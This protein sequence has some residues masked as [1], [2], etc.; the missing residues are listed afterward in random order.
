VNASDEMRR[1][2]EHK[3]LLYRYNFLKALPNIT[4]RIAG[5][6]GTAAT[7]D[8]AVNEKM[9]TDEKQ[10]ALRNYRSLASGIV[11]INVPD[12]LAWSSK[13]EWENVFSPVDLPAHQLRAYID[14]FPR[15][16]LSSSLKA[17]LYT[18]KDEQFIKEERERIE[19]QDV[20]I[21]HPD[22]LSLAVMGLEETPT[23]VLASRIAASLYLLD[24]D[25]LS[26]SDVATSGLDLAK[27]LEV[28]F[29]IDLQMVKA[30]LESCLS[31]A[32]THLHPP[33][34][35]ARALRLSNSV[36]SNE[37]ND[38]EALLCRAYIAQ[39]AG[40][41]AQARD[42]FSNVKDA[43]KQADA[44]S[45]RAKKLRKL[46]ISAN[47]EREA[48]LE[49]AWCDVKL[50]RLEEG[51]E[52]LQEVI[53][54]TDDSV[55]VNR[56]EQAKVWWRLGSC[57]WMMGGSHRDETS[58]A[59]TCFITALKHDSSYAPAFTSLGFYY[60]RASQPVDPSRAVKCFQKAFELDSREDE[61]ARQLAQV[62]ADEDDWD[63][64]YLV[65]RRT[66]DGEGGSL[67]LSGEV[68]S[69]RRHITR[70]SWAW[71]AIGSTE[72]IRQD[73]EK[74]IV[75]FQVAL[76]S[77][78]EDGSIWMRLG[79]AYTASG[80]LEAGIKTFEK[81][82]EIFRGT[83]EEWQPMY[84]IAIVQKQQGKLMEA[85]TRLEELCVVQPEKHEIR[86][87]C[88]EVRLSLSIH[89]IGRGY[90]MRG[91]DGIIASIQEARETAEIQEQLLASWKVVADGLFHYAALHLDENDEEFLHGLAQGIIQ[92]TDHYKVD[93]GLPSIF[94]ATAEVVSSKTSSKKKA[95]LMNVYLNKLRITLHHDDEQVASSVWMDLAQGLHELCSEHAAEQD[96]DSAK[97]CKNQAI[98]CTKEALKREPGNGSYWNSLG[99]LV[100]DSSIKLSQHCYIKAIETDAKDA[101]P[102]TSL[103]FLYLYND[104]DDLAKECFVRAQT[105]DSEYV[106]AWVGQAML[107]KSGKKEQTCR[108]L[109][110]H[111]YAL[112]EGSNL[113][114]AYGYA[115]SLFQA[116][117][118]SP[119]GG[120]QGEGD[121]VSKLTPTSHLQSA[122]FALSAYLAH[123]PRDVSA[124]H[125]SALFAER[126]GD[127]EIAME[128]IERA[129]TILEGQ[130][131]K[132]E[133]AE[134]ASLY[135]ICMV[136]LG[137]I[138]LANGDYEGA[139][140]AFE[141]GSGLLEVE[142]DAGEERKAEEKKIEAA[143]TPRLSASHS[144][145]KKAR[146]GALCG[147][148][149]DW[150]WKKKKRQTNNK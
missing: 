41:W 64:V 83:R 20:D 112:N 51:K 123:R 22:P 98:A 1:E 125:L 45:G 9:Q 136:N 73:Y 147:I 17:L 7:R 31:T 88:A 43:Q 139:K 111:A 52:E 86:I 30:G 4:S 58:Q 14:H 3:L 10:E 70:N 106:Q 114:A 102:W 40:R 87:A 38:I 109:F 140:E 100:F 145:L 62:Y 39:E 120:V 2:A 118:S 25:W 57:L 119:S 72:L 47:P 103:G 71:T 148:S 26:C 132:E 104:D 108:A 55:K 143:P 76:R 28:E 54:D 48:R 92:M 97:D 90:T 142:E 138:R 50:G 32:L 11:A 5:P 63:L 85:L 37:P 126:L 149:I 74:A 78:P 29:A 124:L 82:L 116:L 67:A 12:E 33:Q 122:S 94:S 66:I 137:R 96:T 60:S 144:E 80:R 6:S 131:E 107:A 81:A 68:R 77:F 18:I 53:N 113:E 84:S 91:K 89:Q 129:S 141:M 135:A 121:T 42:Y 65:A 27:R 146:A 130:Y 23:S 117:V 56:E 127:F 59:F 46:S 93:A 105:F 110:Q 13:L 150:C 35:H 15:S 69:Q 134:Q 19:A 115:S 34:H 36:L 75:A 21:A 8:T 44:P 128:R 101:V 49:M 24:R 16:G 79:E 133:S 61:A 99:D 95:L